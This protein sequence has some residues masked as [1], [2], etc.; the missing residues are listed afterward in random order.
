MTQD[1]L[2]AHLQSIIAPLQRPQGVLIMKAR[3]MVAQ[4]MRTLIANSAINA[5]QYLAGV[6][7]DPGSLVVTVIAL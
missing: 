2:Q 3:Q 6:D 5:N 7:G 1:E 4:E